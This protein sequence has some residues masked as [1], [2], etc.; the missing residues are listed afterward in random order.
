MT[1]IMNQQAVKP[2][3]IRIDLIPIDWPLTPL[4]PN[5]DPY[6]MGWQNKPFTKEEIENEIINGKC[7]AIGLL[8]GPTYN[9]P[10]GL[11][12][13]DVDGISVYELIEQISNLPLL[14]ALPPT[15]TILSG[16]AG[17][18]RRLYKVSKEKQK[19]FIRNKYTW[20]SQGSMEKLEILWKRH[21]GVLMGSH[22][23]TQGYFTAEDLGFEWVN[24]LPELPDWVL[25]GIITRNAKQGRP[26]EEV[27]RIIGSSFGITSRIGLERDMQLAVSAMWALPIEAVDDYDIWI[28]IGQSLHELDESLLE[29]WDEWSKQSDKYKEG[30]CHKRW[31]SFTKGGGRGVGTLYHLAEQ[32]GWKRPQEDKVLPP[33]DATID[34]AASILP[35]IERNVEEEMN[36]LLDTATPTDTTPMN[37]EDYGDDVQPKRTRKNKEKELRQPKNEVADKLLDIYENNLLFS[38]P[39]NQFFMYDPSQGLWNK[40]S[41]I[42]ML[43]DIRSRLQKLLL[44]GWLR[45]GFNFQ[46][47]DDMFKQLQ[48]MVPCDKWHEATDVLLFTNGVL[49]VT[50][51]EL[52]PFDRNLHMTQQMPYAYNPEATCEPIIDWLRYTQHGSEKRT[53]VLRAWLRATLLSR[54]ELQKF[55]ELVGPGKSGKSTYAN[56]CVALVGKRN[57]CSTELEQIEKNRFETASFMGKKVILF[58]DSD[59]YGGSVSKLKAITGGD[60]IRSEFKY[61]ADQLEPFQFQGVVIITANEAIQS[62][63]YTS[64]LARRRLTIPFDRPFTGGQA[65]QR[66]LM[67]FDS[68][69]TPEGDFAPLLPGLVNWILDMS[70]S[71][72]REYLMETSKHVNFFQA[73][74]K[75]QAIRSNPILDWLDKRVIFVPGAKAAMGTCKPSPGGANYYVDWATLVYPSYAEHCRG[76][77]VGVSGRSRFEVLLMDICK[78]QLKVNVYTTKNNNGLVVHNILIRDGV[79]SDYKGYP[80]ILEVAADPA[81]YKGMYGVNPAIME[82]H[83]GA[84]H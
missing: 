1:P 42:E 84:N 61:Q 54:H 55:L 14:D 19:H 22:P 74:E 73:Y 7:K 59:R 35:E 65:E 64:G 20:T 12:W 70:E 76:A 33:D 67:G 28:A 13:V 43:G 31:L 45:E 56:L 34:L 37:T 83:I 63:D 10:Y 3:E 27:S 81:K 16:K 25:N 48:S 75:D 82:E 77:N 80:S 52:R 18:E 69:G 30:E 71:E 39:H 4:G 26:A 32:N 8:G 79:K 21:Q 78:N 41:K 49:D 46:M 36:R 5:K 50:T 47:L 53:Q 72:M 68:K 23:D 58:Q 11:V 15:L 6:V 29:Q 38:L 62:T 9:H 40:V 2:G 51:K 44:N 60:W 57:V 66:T 24:K 17:R